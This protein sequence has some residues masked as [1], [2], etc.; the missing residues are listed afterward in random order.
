M[1]VP[2][3]F[4]APKN[5]AVVVPVAT[6][7]ILAPLELAMVIS[8]VV[9]LPYRTSPSAVV[10]YMYALL[11]AET[12]ALVPNRFIPPELISES[13]LIETRLVIPEAYEA[14]VPRNIYDPAP[15]VSE[16]TAALGNVG[17]S[18]LELKYK[19]GEKPSAT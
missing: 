5:R 10:W 7:I 16:K 14:E 18:V 8:S 19:A 9:P 13:G 3:I 1:N 15:V 17:L 11:D 2:P 4:T 6:L 12:K